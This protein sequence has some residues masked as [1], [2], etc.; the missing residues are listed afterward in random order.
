MSNYNFELADF[1]I[2]NTADNVASVCCVDKSY[3]EIEYMNGRK[4]RY[5]YNHVMSEK[6]APRN[7]E[8]ELGGIMRRKW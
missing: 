8:R 2:K 7:I 5:M 3:V 6:R 1:D 4:V